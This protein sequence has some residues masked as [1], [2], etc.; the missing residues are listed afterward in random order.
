MTHFV[1]NTH[2]VGELGTESARVFGMRN[3]QRDRVM[4]RRLRLIN[5]SELADADQTAELIAGRHRAHSGLGS[6][7]LLRRCPHSLL[8]LLVFLRL[9]QAKSNRALVAQKLPPPSAANW[10]AL[11]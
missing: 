4:L 10:H 9:D 7:D 6:C 8:F 5:G 3:F 11:A 2:G 1:R